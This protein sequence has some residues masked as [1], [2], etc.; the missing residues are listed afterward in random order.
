MTANDVD[1]TLTLTIT[2]T[3]DDLR[4][5]LDGPI[6]Q[7]A[8]Q[9]LLESIRQRLKHGHSFKDAEEALEWAQWELVG[10]IS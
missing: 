6:Y 9:D 3:E 4:E 5:Y 10:K 8:V 1:L 7:A 2:G